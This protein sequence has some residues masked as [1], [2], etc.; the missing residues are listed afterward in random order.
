[1]RIGVDPGG[2]LFNIARLYEN[3]PRLWEQWFF[4]D[5]VAARVTPPLH[6]DSSGVRGAAWLWREEGG[7]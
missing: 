2:G 7:P 4:P 3:L 6:G 1:M 5:R